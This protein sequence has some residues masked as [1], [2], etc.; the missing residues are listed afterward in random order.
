MNSDCDDKI[1]SSSRYHHSESCTKL[2]YVY[3]S[4][5]CDE[6]LDYLE[7][8]RRII[9]GH[10]YRRTMSSGTAFASNPDSI[11]YH[12]QNGKT[13]VYQI[14]DTSDYGI[15][16]SPVPSE[17]ETLVTE[18]FCAEKHVLNQREVSKIIPPSLC[19]ATI[20]EA[21]SSYFTDS[22]ELLNSAK[23]VS[24][25][26]V[27]QPIAHSQF[28]KGQL[29]YYHHESLDYHDFKDVEN[30]SEGID[31]SFAVF[32][33]FANVLEETDSVFEEL[34][35][36]SFDDTYTISDDKVRRIVEIVKRHGEYTAADTGND[37]EQF[38]DSDVTFSAT[39]VETFSASR[40]PTPTIHFSEHLQPEGTSSTINCEDF[41][42]NVFQLPCIF[43]N[44]S[45][46]SSSSTGLDN[47]FQPRTSVDLT[48]FSE[49]KHIFAQNS[50]QPFLDSKEPDKADATSENTSTNLESG[51]SGNSVLVNM[52]E[53]YVKMV[54]DASKQLNQCSRNETS[55]DNVSTNTS[56]SS[57]NMCVLN[58]GEMKLLKEKGTKIETWQQRS[59]KTEI[60]NEG[61]EIMKRNRFDGVNQN[62]AISE[63]TSLKNNSVDDN[64]SETSDKPSKPQEL[65]K[66]ENCE[67]QPLEDVVFLP[68]AP[69]KS[70]VEKW[71][72]ATLKAEM[73][74]NMDS[75]LS[76]KPEKHEDYK[77][78][79]DS[80]CRMT[81]FI[82]NE[83]K[84][85][86][87]FGNEHSNPDQMDCTETDVQQQNKEEST[88]GPILDT[89]CSSLLLFSEELCNSLPTSSYSPF[90]NSSNN[91]PETYD[92]EIPSKKVNDKGFDNSNMLS[93]P[94]YD[95]SSQPK[96]SS[97]ASIDLHL[98]KLDD[99]HHWKTKQPLL[100]SSLKTVSSD[101]EKNN[102]GLIDT[103]PN[104]AEENVEE[105]L[106]KT[107]PF[108]DGNE[109]VVA[110]C[111]SKEVN[112]KEKVR[113]NQEPGNVTI[114]PECLTSENISCGSNFPYRGSLKSSIDTI[115]N[116]ITSSKKNVSESE[117]C[118]NSMCPEETTHEGYDTCS[119]TKDANSSSI[120]EDAISSKTSSKTETKVDCSGGL[121]ILIEAS[122]HSD[123]EVVEVI[124]LLVT[125]VSHNLSEFTVELSPEPATSTI[126]SYVSE[127]VLLD[128]AENTKLGIPEDSI[129][130]VDEWKGNERVEDDSRNREIETN[131]VQ[132]VKDHTENGTN[133]FE[134]SE[135]EVVLLTLAEN[136][137]EP[138]RETSENEVFDFNKEETTNSGNQ[139][140]AKTIE[141]S[142]QFDILEEVAIEVNK[143]EETCSKSDV[144]R[145][146]DKRLA[147]TESCED[148]GII[149]L[150][151]NTVNVENTASLGQDYE[152]VALIEQ[153]VDTVSESDSDRITTALVGSLS[154][155]SSETRTSCANAISHDTIGTVAEEVKEVVDDLL[156]TVSSFVI[157]ES[158]HSLD[159]W[160]E[161]TEKFSNL[162][163][164]NSIQDVFC[165]TFDSASSLSAE[166]S[167]PC[168]QI[169]DS[170]ETNYI[171]SI[172]QFAD[173]NAEDTL[174]IFDLVDELTRLADNLNMQENVRKTSSDHENKFGIETVRE[175]VDTIIEGLLDVVCNFVVV[176]EQ[177]ENH[178][179]PEVV[180][181]SI[182]PSEELIEERPFELLKEEEITDEN[183]SFEGDQEL[184]SEDDVVN[185]VDDLLESILDEPHHNHVAD[186]LLLVNSVNE[187]LDDITD[188]SQNDQ[189]LTDSNEGDTEV[190]EIVLSLLEKI[191]HSDNSDDINETTP[192]SHSSDLNERMDDVCASETEQTAN[193][194]KNELESHVK[195]V[196][197]MLMDQ[198]IDFLKQYESCEDE[199]LANEIPISDID[200]D[201]VSA[202][203]SDNN[204]AAPSFQNGFQNDTETADVVALI[205][206]TE[207]S[208][209]SIDS[210]SENDKEI[211]RHI[212]EVVNTLLSAFNSTI[213][214]DDN[215]SNDAIY[216]QQ[217]EYSDE[218]SFEQ[219]NDNGVS[220]DLDKEQDIIQIV[221]DS[222]NP[223]TSSISS[224][225][226]T[227]SHF[228]KPNTSVKLQDN[229]DF[230]AMN[231]EISEVI[232]SL[233]DIVSDFEDSALANQLGQENMDTV[234]CVLNEIM[235]SV[236]NDSRMVGTN[237]DAD[238]ESCISEIIEQLLDDV[239]Q[240]NNLERKKRNDKY[241]N[242]EDMP[243][244]TEHQESSNQFHNAV[245][246][247]FKLIKEERMS[248]GEDNQRSENHVTPTKE[249][250]GGDFENG[251]K[252]CS[253][254][255]ESLKTAMREEV[256]V[257]KDSFDFEDSTNESVR[258]L[259]NMK[260]STILIPLNAEDNSVVVL[261]KRPI[262][263]T[264]AAEHF[265]KIE[266]ASSNVWHESSLEIKREE[267]KP[268]Q[269][270]DMN[271]ESCLN[272]NILS[273]IGEYVE[274][275]VHDQVSFAMT[276]AAT[277]RLSHL[278]TDTRK[279]SEQLDVYLDLP[280][281]VSLIYEKLTT[282]E[283]PSLENYEL[284]GYCV[285][286]KDKHKAT[287]LSDTPLFTNS[288]EISETLDN[289]ISQLP[290]VTCLCVPL[291]FSNGEAE[292][293]I[294]EDLLMQPTS[295]ICTPVLV[296]P[297]ENT[298]DTER[299]A[300]AEVLLNG[301]TD[302]VQRLEVDKLL[303]VDDNQNFESSLSKCDIFEDK[304]QNSSSVCE[305]IPSIS[306]TL[307]SELSK[308]SHNTTIL[309]YLKINVNEKVCNV[310]ANTPNDICTSSR[311]LMNEI[312]EE[313]KHD[314]TAGSKTKDLNPLDTCQ[315]STSEGRMP[316]QHQMIVEVSRDSPSSYSI[317]RFNFDAAA[318]ASDC[319][320][321]TD[322]CDTVPTNSSL[323][324][325][326]ESSSTESSLKS[327]EQ[328][329]TSSVLE[330]V[331]HFFA[332]AC[333][334]ALAYMSPSESST[335][336]FNSDIIEDASKYISNE[337][338]S[339]NK[340][341][342]K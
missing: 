329:S 143:F 317:N 268:E 65:T 239:D 301:D 320:L 69:R 199:I 189:T 272:F 293:L 180:D 83:D 166:N 102:A 240:A 324:L 286:E 188:V 154:L 230:T 158:T 336:L 340:G 209:S 129:T 183:G 261:D 224:D 212:L 310:Y 221:I 73:L 280:D 11:Q 47:D 55:Q 276:D 95:P 24:T 153:M 162:Y 194:N 170:L 283:E 195:E 61:L 94:T 328:P 107:L 12:T 205:A 137:P 300:T 215:D 243:A 291:S 278:V 78:D 54:M 245:D 57:S 337:L 255:D 273:V 173:S 140:D 257:G 184:L 312:L 298:L 131:I 308:V 339:S 5:Q 109:I 7:E 27:S 51:N 92:Q 323:K 121:A 15:T 305:S 238:D 141:T 59:D 246:E 299:G 60:E 45:F 91:L 263:A 210:T 147:D 265:A 21:I 175:E 217:K 176:E 110:D 208:T 282:G 82:G 38:P 304:D 264:D 111:N 108:S 62:V 172:I 319:S 235:N 161:D 287:E 227:V 216:S 46:T 41:E 333:V 326:T 37:V 186:T 112:D 277:F 75:S 313:T 126:I 66:L 311:T 237:D 23:L 315:Q 142:I 149:D 266:Q 113:M 99:S 84:E 342:G 309:D 13:L 244:S 35:N 145:L 88:S 104:I 247:C 302:I 322:M 90:E 32:E 234:R 124:D 14:G 169:V 128:D 133:N 125:T 85:C 260:S 178:F 89:E 251:E 213:G 146:E 50:S 204:S 39:P 202:T 1:K 97:L 139:I 98:T 105:Q 33:E 250:M 31:D 292:D 223:I 53:D 18:T 297:S 181:V 151:S 81:G 288:E 256:D 307:L 233:L 163:V 207:F 117:G 203:E 242:F 229:I 262:T 6:Y 232:E 159:Y 316:L 332:T 248:G 67:D 165:D 127:C 197:E 135:A 144:T 4:R 119:P 295:G 249:A 296:F 259:E 43:N 314:D 164:N 114:E 8:L 185:V 58:V 225:H 236:E 28:Q 228:N 74:G 281:S 115:G 196:V 122:T 290:T 77:S 132:E 275:L 20:E 22:K 134:T 64:V 211:D 79:S 253:K 200:V 190:T 171:S 44:R 318:E 157:Q 331:S 68:I 10:N 167:F 177:D 254:I 63:E 330:E 150:I 193:E 148:A 29:D 220:S 120:F 40:A 269:Y 289:V 48:N 76:S 42:S 26:Y 17:T 19:H 123:Q 160:F 327:L 294:E 116:R 192:D 231:S 130:K 36:E 101:S 270:L 80:I 222:S 191:V 241:Q 214:Q 174:Q 3:T 252:T 100:L 9:F 155:K 52:I 138:Q 182:E 271:T 34:V 284:G 334:A 198:V 218:K 285:L 201:T 136:D 152:I 72:S 279:T 325:F 156:E 226:Q 86:R 49:N 70:S 87:T 206:S 118:Q 267:K 338:E 179:D 258:N 168:S 335:S 30:L 187:N 2:N 306:H 341:S 96:K 25:D 56:S 16:L 303:E 71:E 219:L 93:N 274:C 103:H 106:A 321:C